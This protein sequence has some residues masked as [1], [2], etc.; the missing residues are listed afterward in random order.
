MLPVHDLQWLQRT[1]VFRG[2]VFSESIAVNWLW[3]Y[4]SEGLGIGTR[5]SIGSLCSV[6]LLSLV[7]ARAKSRYERRRLIITW[8][9]G[10][11]VTSTRDLTLE[12]PQQQ[13]RLGLATSL[14]PIKS[15]SL[16]G[17]LSVFSVILP[18][19]R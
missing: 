1:V 19:Q 8:R 3:V 15:L 4:V 17:R 9:K 12:S 5:M 6:S 2:S 18:H 16:P 10:V 7:T 13:R 14:D 11:N